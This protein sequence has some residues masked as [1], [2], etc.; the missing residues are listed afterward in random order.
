MYKTALQSAAV[1]GATGVALGAF[2]AHGLPTYL[3]DA[4]FDA[5]ALA[6]R[7]ETFI[8]GT[9]YQLYAALA[10]LAIGLGGEAATFR[11]PVRLLS[12][13]A[14]IFS[15]LL[16]ALAL[17][18]GFRWLGAI[19]P[20]GGLA[21]IAGWVT[22]GVAGWTARAQSTEERDLLAAEVHRLEEV[23]THQQQVVEALDEAVTAVRD[24]SDQTTR[25]SVSIEQTV[26]RLADYQQG[27]EDLPDE[28]PPHY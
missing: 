20:V 23:L 9:R 17:I 21:M 2:G 8:T 14:V 16:Y 27:A 24:A 10:L 1:L 7:L 28:R 11:W 19:V 3:E 18:E 5:A 4:G 6:T 13:G 25:R 15:G 26:K 12:V 22:I